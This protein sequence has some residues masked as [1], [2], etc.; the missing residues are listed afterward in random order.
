MIAVIYL[1]WM[2]IEAFVWKAC[3][4]FWRSLLRLGP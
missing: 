2:K 3:S 1:Y 4:W